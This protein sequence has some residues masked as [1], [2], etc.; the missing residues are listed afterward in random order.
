MS[1]RGNPR[2][3]HNLSLANLPIFTL[4]LPS[5]IEGEGGMALIKVNSL[6][7]ILFVNHVPGLFTTDVLG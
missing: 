4:T 3:S 5:P 1:R 2:L 6:E 7:N